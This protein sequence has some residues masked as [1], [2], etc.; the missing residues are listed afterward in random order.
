MARKGR[1]LADFEKG[2]YRW[3]A[4]ALKH[5]VFADP[6]NTEAKELLADA[7]EQMAYQAESGTWRSVYVQGAFELR[8]GV[9]AA[10]GLNTASPDTIKAMPPEMTFD[11]LAVRLNGEKAAG[12]KIT[13]NLN[14]TDLGQ[15]YTLTVENSVLN[16]SKRPAASPDAT[17]TLTKS[18]LDR[19]QL[20]EITA[21][22]ATAG[23][24]LQIEGP[25]E[26]LDEL[27]GL[28][29]TFPF[30]FNIVTP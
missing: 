8:N 12:K 7:Y 6:K 26:A 17:L 18:T 22:D 1:A 29:D 3:I 28:F 19:I 13:V 21:Q 2:E 15:T 14:F 16:Y 10:G 25:R 20:G 30:W 9:P 27:V 24:D 23:G 5:V 11:Y 4:E